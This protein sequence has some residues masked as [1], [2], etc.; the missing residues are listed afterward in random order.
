MQ[1]SIAV[2]ATQP[3]LASQAQSLAEQ[4]HLPFLNN[5][6]TSS[7]NYLIIVTPNYVGLQKTNSK[8]HPLYVDFLSSQMQYRKL[9]LSIRKEAV[10]R[11][12]GLKM[13]SQVKILDATAGLARD[14]FILACLGFQVTLLERS[15]II[16]SLIADG[17]KR[18]KDDPAVQRLHL[19][20]ANAISWLKQCDN[21]NRPDLIYLDPMFPQRSKSALPKKN[22]ALFQA[23]VG[24]DM[25]ADILL[26]KS[27]AC[28]KQRVVV[29]RSRL[30]PSL[31]GPE[32]SYSLKGSSS[33][34]DV[35]VI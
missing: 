19:I 32:P 2:F 5:I 11:A 34:F 15:P 27:L 13:N 26:A 8:S 25:D 18:A 28:A 35:Y 21:S 9:H 30:A 17:I 22:M 6:S 33:R 10:A 20:Q 24:D 12:L 7:Y 31:K 16:Y 3:G 29:K 4:L 14:S 1:I 23:I